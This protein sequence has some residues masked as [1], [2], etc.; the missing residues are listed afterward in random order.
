MKHSAIITLFAIAG[1][2]P[3]LGQAGPAG[4]ERMLAGE[5]YRAAAA[6]IE[7]DHDRTVAEIITLTEIPAPPFGEAARAAAYAEMLRE[8]GLTNVEIDA[9]GNAMGLYRGTGAPGGPVVAIAAHLDTVFPAE[10]DVKVRREGD[11]LIA[12]GIGDDTRS[13]AVLLAYA[14][15][16][17]DN[18]VETR[19]DPPG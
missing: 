6:Q 13:L 16:L 8:A 11:R 19:R 10:T 12:P 2:S 9:E 15:A 1:A 18:A 7:R 4:V 14:R 17:R 3:A 5:A